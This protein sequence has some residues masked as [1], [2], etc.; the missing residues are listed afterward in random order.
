MTFRN[1]FA[2]AFASAFAATFATSGNIIALMALLLFAILPVDTA[3]SAAVLDFEETG[4]DVI[5]KL[6]G[7]LN[8]VGLLHGTC[9]CSESAVLNSSAAWV[10]TS[11]SSGN[12]IFTR[13]YA[14][15]GPT[16]FGSGAFLF[17]SSSTG[18]FIDLVGINSYVELDQLY[19]AHSQ[20]Q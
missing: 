7:S 19:S 1:L 15:T 5:A 20:A 14:V 11:T 18:S 9:F 4:G 3:K 16:S 13:Q 10:D 8:V 12:Q 17:A 6:S 2:G